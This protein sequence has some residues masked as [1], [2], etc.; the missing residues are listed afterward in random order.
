MESNE[1]PTTPTDRIYKT[2]S[3]ANTGS[4][5]FIY[6]KRKLTKI[7]AFYKNTIQCTQTQRIKVLTSY[8]IT[9]RSS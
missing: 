3:G 8:I 4:K 6:N 1:K 9:E 7:R 2:Y 5:M